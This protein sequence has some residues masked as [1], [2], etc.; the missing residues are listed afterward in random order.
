MSATKNEDKQKGHTGKNL[1]RK[2]IKSVD[3]IEI[4][5][6][7]WSERKSISSFTMLREGYSYFRTFYSIESGLDLRFQRVLS[8]LIAHVDWYNIDG[9]WGVAEGDSQAKISPV[10]H[11]REMNQIFDNFIEIKL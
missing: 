1:G 5:R 10:P 7:Y 9:F 3:I 2:V 8:S 4:F 11:T 6:Y